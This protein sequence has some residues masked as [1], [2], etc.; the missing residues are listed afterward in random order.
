MNHISES[1]FREYDI[2]GVV[3]TE[4]QDQVVKR[5]AAATATLFSR[6]G[7]NMIA[8]GMDGRPSSEHIKELVIERLTNYG[9]HAIDIGLVPT[10][11]LYYVVFKENLGGGI[12]ITASHNPSEYNG[13]KILL[14]KSALY[15]DQI[16][17]LYRIAVSDRFPGEKRGDVEKRNI[18]QEYI[19]YITERINLRKRIRV[20]VDCG[21]G[22]AGLTALPLYKKMGADV[23]GLY[24]D[25]D[26]TFPN[27]HPD[28]TKV[29]N[30]QDMISKVKETDAD[31]GISFDGDGDRIGVVDKA[32]NIIW[33]DQLMIIFARN[34]LKQH[35]RAKII[36]EVK[37]SQVLYSEIE[38]NGGVPIMWKTGHS[39]IKKKIFEENAMLAGEVS[40]HIFFND[41]WFGFDDAVYAG[42]RLLELLANGEASLGDILETIPKT[43]NTPEIRIDTQE[44]AKFKIVSDI[45]D[46]FQKTH[47]VIDIDGARIKFPHGWGLIRAS[48]TQPSLVLRFEADSEAHLKQYQ[49]EVESV[50]S[51]VRKK[52]ES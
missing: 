35:P 32:G 48:N 18:L 41:R 47:D 11:V 36:S 46:M 5:I 7:K 28:P 52:H 29:E 31:L 9:L 42:A 1:I 34:I 40:G 44:E 3:E 45:K 16:K 23:I 25:V 33:G 14:G 4:L 13:F 43:Y 15:G 37:A 17:E 27:H 38:K 24:C 39:L 50:L 6:E 19:A 20:V 22:T 21:N 8:V 26:G 12:V 51:E 10:P 30:L 2:R 49:Q